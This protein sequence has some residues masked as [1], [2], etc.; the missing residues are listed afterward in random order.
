MNPGYAGRAELPDF[1]GSW[2]SMGLF[3]GAWGGFEGWLD[4]CFSFQ[5]WVV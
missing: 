1:I 2:T 4:A 3:L 5:D